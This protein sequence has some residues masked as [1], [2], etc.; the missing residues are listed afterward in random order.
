[1]EAPRPASATVAATPL[2]DPGDVLTRRRQIYQRVAG[3]KIHVEFDTASNAGKIAIEES[4]FSRIL[5]N[6]VGN[7]IDAMPE[8]GCLRITLRPGSRS[9]SHPRQ[10]DGS[11]QASMPKTVMLRVCDTGEG[12]A[13]ERLPYIFDAGV[14]SKPIREDRQLRGFG[15][16]IVRE[17]TDQAGGTIRV[18][19]HAGR[20]S[21]F[22]LEFPR[23]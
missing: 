13:P 23:A 7:A 19:S 4:A 22:E 17:L 2:L 12:I 8:G 10:A 11:S 14:S 3:D 21:C 18:R 5:Y 16:A 6:L 1:M 20:G 9:G 15:L